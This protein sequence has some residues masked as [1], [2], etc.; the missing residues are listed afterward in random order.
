MKKAKKLI[1]IHSLLCSTLAFGFDLGNIAK[2]VLKN[3]TNTSQESKSSTHTLNNDTVSSGLKE[4][5]K[6]GVNY[7]VETLGKEKGYLTN[8]LVKIPLPQNLQKAET[9][10]RKVGGD[11]IADNLIK[12]MNNAATQAAPKTAEIFINAIEKMSLDDAK[13]ILDGGNDAATQYFKTNTN[14]ALKRVIKPIIKKTMAQNSVANY[15]SSFNSYYKEYAKDYVDNTQVMN[16]AKNF[17]VDSYLPSSSEED[18]DDYVT[19][20][21]IDGLFTMIAKK[22]SAIRSNPIEQ[23]S[24]LLKKVFSK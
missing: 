14:E 21:A 20:K 3:T 9:I 10:V 24:S 5:L 12:S 13:K 22:E 17:G 19:K 1:I 11:K 16:L 8:S 7:A 6:V 15:Y 18:L 4:A 2:E 23:T